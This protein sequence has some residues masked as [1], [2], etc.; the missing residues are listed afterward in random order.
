MHFLIADDD[1]VTAAKIEAL[2]TPYGACDIAEN[3]QMALCKIVEAMVLECPFDFVTM[4]ID[5]PGLKGQAVVKA[6][7]EWEELKDI[8]YPSENSAKIVMMTSKE[9][10]SEIAEAYKEFCDGYL[11]KPITPQKLEPILQKFE[12]A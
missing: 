4:D 2:L 7:R 9:D 8:P 3:G 6:I 12:I 1:E 11:V 10:I 5:M